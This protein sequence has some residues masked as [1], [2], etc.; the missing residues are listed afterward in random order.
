MK[1]KQ[2]GA[3]CVLCIVLTLVVLAFAVGGLRIGQAYIQNAEINSVFKAMASD[4]ETANAS[5]AEVRAAFGRRAVVADIKVVKPEELE[6]SREEG[7]LVLSAEYSVKVPVI[8]NASL[9]LEF[10]P[11]NADR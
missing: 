4:A 5:N 1:A 2:T 9:I 11:S 8:S 10:N 7:K 3:S 6:I